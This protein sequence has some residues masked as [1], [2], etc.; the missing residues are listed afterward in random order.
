MQLNCIW[1][2]FYSILVV[3][4]GSNYA[5]KKNERK[6]NQASGMRQPRRTIKT[7]GESLRK[8]SFSVAILRYYIRRGS[9][10]KMI[11]FAWFKQWNWTKIAFWII[12]AI[13]SGGIV[14]VIFSAVWVTFFKL[15]GWW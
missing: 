5:K 2:Y 1:W 6:K 4:Q 10:K 3:V 13:I 8:R 9:G 7:F 11:N 12:A 14:I 15:C